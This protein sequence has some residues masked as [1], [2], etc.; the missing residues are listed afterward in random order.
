MGE[1]GRFATSSGGSAWLF[2]P[3]TS[4]AQLWRSGGTSA[5]TVIVKDINP[6]GGNSLDG[7]I[8]LLGTKGIVFGANDGGT[9]G[10]E[11]WFSDGTA[12]TPTE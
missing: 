1:R 9:D 6:G 5:G 7:Q 3:S 8:L 11:P 12:E 4:P 2:S 10:K